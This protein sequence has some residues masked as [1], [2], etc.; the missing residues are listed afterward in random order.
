M[1][2]AHFQAG[3]LRLFCARSGGCNQRCGLICATGRGTAE[4]ASAA[5]NISARGGGVGRLLVSIIWVATA[6][7]VGQQA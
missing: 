3:R 7:V 4:A 5:S 2:E 1:A 6:A